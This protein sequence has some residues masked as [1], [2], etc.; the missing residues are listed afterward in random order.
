MPSLRIA[1]QRM[2]RRPAPANCLSPQSDFGPRPQGRRAAEVLAGSSATMS[3]SPQE[4]GLCVLLWQIERDRPRPTW[5]RCVRSVMAKRL[6]MRGCSL[7]CRRGLVDPRTALW[8]PQRRIEQRRNQLRSALRVN[9]RNHVSRQASVERLIDEDY[10][11]ASVMDRELARRLVTVAHRPCER[12][13]HS[14][15]SIDPWLTSVAPSNRSCGHYR[16]CNCA[17][18]GPPARSHPVAARRGAKERTQ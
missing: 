10:L 7:S 14:R 11:G 1:R 18:T 16:R 17:K 4:R 3:R 13:A 15:R 6:R 12:T 8:S 5:S 2:T 9:A